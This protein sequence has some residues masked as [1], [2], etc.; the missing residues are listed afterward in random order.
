M[1]FK[2]NRGLMLF[3]GICYGL[4]EIIWRG[5]THWSMLLTGGACF[6]ALFR[7]FRKIEGLPTYVRCVCGGAVITFCEFCSGCVFNRLL[8]LRVWDYSENRLNLKGQICAFYSAMWVLL[9]YP[10]M[11]LCAKIKAED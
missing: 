11:K 7:L 3:G 2:S 4:I 1:R 9:S 6:C 5:K 10:V 8:K